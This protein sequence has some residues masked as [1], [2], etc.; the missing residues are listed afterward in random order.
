MFYQKLEDLWKEWEALEEKSGCHGNF[1]DWFH[2]Y[3]V[4]SIVSGMLR[5]IREDAGLGVPPSTFTTNASESLNAL[6]KRKVDFKRS[7]LTVFI[8]YLKQ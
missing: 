4:D 1:Y 7:E 5:P 6:L 3:K 2:K 8:E